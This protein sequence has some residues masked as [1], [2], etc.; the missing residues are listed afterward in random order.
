M[1]KLFIIIIIAGAVSGYLARKERHEFTRVLKQQQ[2]ILVT[3][4]KRKEMRDML[5]RYLSYNLV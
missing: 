1:K 2:D 3:R 5:A 4:Q